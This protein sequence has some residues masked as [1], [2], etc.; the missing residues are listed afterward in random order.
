VVLVGCGAAEEV[1]TTSSAIPAPTTTA[2]PTST[3]IVPATT[4]TTTGV[5]TTE[6]TSGL[7]G[8]PIDFGPAEGDVL[9]VIG[10]AHDDVLNLRS[11]PGADQEILAGIPPLYSDLVAFGA[12]RQMAASMW[13]QVDYS[14]LAGWVNLRFVAY[15]GT[16]GDITTGVIDTFGEAPV[17]ESM[18][19]LGLVIADNIIAEAAGAIAVMSAAPTPAN[20]GEVT[21]DV[22]GFEDDSVRG[23]RIHVIGGPSNGRF[24]LVSVE[25]TPFCSRGVDD[26][27]FCV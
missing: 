15:L 26:S 16:T 14:G 24:T 19:E 8:D 12:T 9:A 3:T 17:A 13:I 23:E 1:A 27:G 22:V 7:P 21:Y 2:A 20:P 6:S 4:T 5:S 18:E 25:V 11:A 10:V